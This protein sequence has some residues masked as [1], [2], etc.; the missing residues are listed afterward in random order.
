M[1]GGPS[2]RRC[3]EAAAGAGGQ[4][5]LEVSRSREREGHPAR[6]PSQHL[7]MLERGG[8]GPAH[9]ALLPREEDCELYVR[10]LCEFEPG[11]VLPFLQSVDSYR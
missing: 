11:A 3:G 2:G 7:Q 6:A 1:W 8:G 10:L 5:A 9:A 4:A